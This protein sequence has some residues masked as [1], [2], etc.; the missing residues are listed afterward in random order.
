MQILLIHVIQVSKGIFL[1]LCMVCKYI[2]FSKASTYA[3][4]NVL[5]AQQKAANITKKSRICW[6]LQQGTQP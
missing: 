1:H 2:V 6:S 3:A 4:A 5:I